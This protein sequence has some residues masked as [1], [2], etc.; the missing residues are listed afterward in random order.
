MDLGMAIIQE[1]LGQEFEQFV[2]WQGVA[3]RLASLCMEQAR[4]IWSLEDQLSRAESRLVRL[5]DEDVLAEVKVLLADGRKIG[6]VK[7]IRE[8]AHPSLVV[9]K[10]I[11]DTIEAE[12][13]KEA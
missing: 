10:K 7:L 4:E 8:K 9:A 13:K 5:L 12:M 3:K 2:D 6:A 1:R 11:A